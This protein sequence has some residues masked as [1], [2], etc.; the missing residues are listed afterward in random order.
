MDE[1][2]WLKIAGLIVLWLILAGALWEK[3]GVKRYYEVETVFN[4][5]WR[6][7][8]EGEYLVA[9]IVAAI[10]IGAIIFV[11]YRWKK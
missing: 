9:G 7:P 3:L 4:R 11:R 8:F 2:R 5:A 1:D 10:V 6:P